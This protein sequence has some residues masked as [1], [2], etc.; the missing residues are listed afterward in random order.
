MVALT[1]PRLSEAQRLSTELAQALAERK[2]LALAV[3]RSTPDSARA[4]S[5]ALRAATARVDAL[6]DALERLLPPADRPS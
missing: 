4:T 2:A 3:G 6:L 5:S 1:P